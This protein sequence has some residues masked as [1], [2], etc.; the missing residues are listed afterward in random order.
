MDVPQTSSLLRHMLR[1]LETTQ[2]QDDSI[3]LVPP[4]ETDVSRG[5]DVNEHA[6]NRLK[7]STQ[8]SRQQAA[9]DEN[10]PGSGLST[11]T[12]LSNYFDVGEEDCA[13]SNNPDDPLCRTVTYQCTNSRLA[14]T[15]PY[16]Y[17]IHFS[18]SDSSRLSHY[19]EVVEGN[20][21]HY[22]AQT[23]NLD[24]CAKTLEGRRVG[25]MASEDLFERVTGVSLLP[26][27]TIGQQDCSG[28]HI[29]YPS[30]SE[31]SPPEC[32]SVKGSLTLFTLFNSQGSELSEEEVL[33]LKQ[34][35]IDEIKLGMS[36]N[37][38]LASTTSSVRIRM[39]STTVH[40]SPSS[41][42]PKFSARSIGL[43]TAAGILA[44]SLV[45]A[46]LYLRYR[47]KNEKGIPYVQDVG[48][49]SVVSD[50]SHDNLGAR[51]DSD[52]TD[53]TTNGGIPRIPQFESTVSE[54][55]VAASLNQVE[56]HGTEMI[57]FEQASELQG[58]LTS[59]DVGS[60]DL[61]A[62]PTNAT[63]LGDYQFSYD[64]GISP[65]NETFDN[66]YE[67]VEIPSTFDETSRASGRSTPLEH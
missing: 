31:A 19:M 46:C 59:F 28:E 18:A 37:K 58:T 23:M 27:D 66:L 11:S 33:S 34:T 53:P 25:E 13:F 63:D 17:E 35:V 2:V 44:V 51:C 36:E 15:V 55:V 22:L 5:E 52:V 7:E 56:S 60:Y 1:E 41:T 54:P 47:L 8:F 40:G 14:L 43:F 12:G 49:S 4:D 67:D 64:Q 21:L 62:L 30:S 45:A 65:M 50:P 24:A 42:G 57:E 38:F 9:R 16:D 48:G 29:A 20:I 6:P 10:E 26:R 61:E 32:R 39:P 3:E